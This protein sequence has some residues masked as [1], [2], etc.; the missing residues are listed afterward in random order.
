MRPLPQM[1]ETKRIIVKGTSVRLELLLLA[2]GAWTLGCGGGGAGSVTPPPPSPS[3]ISMSIRP[4]SGT[5]FLGGTLSFSASAS[6]ATN[7]SVTWAVN[8]VPGGSTQAGTIS[9]NGIYTAPIDLPSG[10]TVQVTAISQADSS[11]SA[12]ASVTVSSDIFIS[13]SQ[14]SASVELGATQPFQATIKSQGHPDSSVRWSLSGASCPGACGAVDAN[15]NYVAPQIL[16]SSSAVT[17]TASSVADSSK[18]ASAT[19]TV[20]SHF[21]LQLSAPSNL[22]PGATASLVAMLTPV[23]GSNPS[24]ALSWSLQGSGCAGSSCGVLTVTATQSAGVNPATTTAVYTAPMTVP[25]PNSVVI[26]VVPQADHSKQT[27][28]IIT[29]QAGSSISLTPP[30]ATLAAN[31]QITLRAALDGATGGSISWAVN[32]I[33]G[34]N[35]TVGQVLGGPAS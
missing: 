30:N 12:M 27:Q 13:L 19:I 8:G 33:T 15:G 10:G 22:L 31:H 17:L 3:P 28:A 23:S 7:T 14:N 26:T 24:S 9:A 21:T 18:Q 1:R 16:P 6:N 5:V 32:G 34:G 11:K 35:A 20:T 4:T 29:I 25:Q 2:M